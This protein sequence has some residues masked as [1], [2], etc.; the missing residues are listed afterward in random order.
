MSQ[1]D[2]DIANQGFAAFRADLNNALKALGSTSSGT[3]EPATTYANQ[4]WYETDTNILHIRNES[5][6]AWLDLMVINQT[7]GSPSFTA[8]NVGIG[9]AAPSQPLTIEATT[10]I[11]QLVD[12]TLTTRVANIGGDNGSVT[13]DIDPA[14]TASSSFFSVNIDDTERARIDASGNLL[15]GKTSAS[16]TG[17]GIYMNPIGYMP[18]TRAGTSGATYIQIVNDNGTIGSITGS[19]TTTSYNTSSDYRLK[20]DVQP[21]VGASDRVLSLNPVNFAWKA[22]GTRV[23]GFIAH[24]AQA[25]VPEAVYGDKDAVDADGKPVYQGI[26]QSKLVPL[27]TA[28]LQEALKRIE[29]LEACITA[30][31][32]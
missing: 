20:K 24:E 3:E 10:P 30:L 13:I 7:T 14:Q 32:A 11:I 12:S 9:T 23:D 6:S 5:N 17:A 25:V 4:L 22:D 27:L 31:E 28:A 29:A 19:G 21:M 1:H 15:V 26:D 2:F 16:T 8:G 18:I